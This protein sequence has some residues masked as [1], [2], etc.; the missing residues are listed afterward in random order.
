MDV[1]SPEEAQRLFD[2]LTAKGDEIA[3]R[4]LKEGCECRAQLMIE[5]MQAL[6]LNPGRAWAV[7]V[8]RPLTVT[9]RL[10]PR[11]VSEWYNHV[12]PAFRAAGVTHEAWV[13]D[14]V[15]SGSGPMSIVGWAE[16]MRARAIDVSTLPL[17]QLEILNRQATRVMR[18]EAL[19]AILF[20]LE[21]GQ[22][23]IPELGGS[24]F[25]LAPDPPEGASEFARMTMQKLLA[26]EQQPPPGRS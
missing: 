20:L 12:A 22:P 2:A 18:G 9:D 8:G 10:A 17:S 26:L 23:P 16:A 25:R 15:L 3:F 24:G 4:W 14:P 21:F 19:D 5:Y 6:G 7:A 13:I 1:L 11:G